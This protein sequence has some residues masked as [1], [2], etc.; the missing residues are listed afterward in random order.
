[1]HRNLLCLMTMAALV[2]PAFAAEWTMDLDAAKARAAA[3]GK[4]VLISFTGSDWCPMCAMLHRNVLG[5]E[6]FGRYAADRFVLVEIDVPRNPTFSEEQLERN[7][8]VCAQFGVRAMP[9]VLVISPEGQVL[10]GFRGGKRSFDEVCEVLNAAVENGDLFRTAQ[11]LQG[12]ERAKILLEVHRNI[13]EPFRELS[14][15]ESEVCELDADNATGVY[16]GD[17]DE[18]EWNGILAS[19]ASAKGD[20]AEEDAILAKAIAHARP[21]NVARVHALKEQMEFERLQARVMRLRLSAPKD[22]ISLLDEA[23]PN[24]TNPTHR[25]QLRAYKVE[26]Q[27]RAAETVEDI[28]AAKQTMLDSAEDCPGSEYRIRLNAESMFNEPEKLLEKAKAM[29]AGE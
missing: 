20:A 1:M 25:Y 16:D 26:C 19:L 4:V 12:L 15:L 28:M 14:T 13:P 21:D 8:E 5:R 6:E 11:K 23:I 10:G 7:H 22:A 18:R 27:I 3:E 9:T 2:A 17:L 24:T 29:R